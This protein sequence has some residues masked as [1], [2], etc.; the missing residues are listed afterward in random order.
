[1]TLVP[2][3]LEYDCMYCNP[4]APLMLI[5]SGVV[6]ERITIAAVAP[7]YCEVTVTVGGEICGYCAI[8]SVGIVTSPASNTTK[9][10]TAAKCGRF[11]KNSIMSQLS[12][13]DLSFETSVRTLPREIPCYCSRLL[14]CPSICHL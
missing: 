9:L 1:M 10:S 3:A 4:S 11:R 7:G 12:A 13:K 5:S 2:L 14:G 6:T 8:G